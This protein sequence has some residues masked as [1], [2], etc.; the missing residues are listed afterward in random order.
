M[1][2]LLLTVEEAAARLNG[3]VSLK[4]IREAIL[5]KRLAAVKH[6]RRYFITPA[7]LERFAACP[8]RA[9]RRASGDAPQLTS[10]SSSIAISPVASAGQALAEQAVRRLRSRSSRRT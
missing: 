2:S 6:G 10:G 9:S 1:D 3:I 5:K 4:Y 8:D 7:E